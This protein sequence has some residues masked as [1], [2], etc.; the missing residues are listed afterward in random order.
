[1]APNY[2]VSCVNPRRQVG[3]KALETQDLDFDELRS[4]HPTDRNEYIEEEL[5]GDQPS[6]AL[7]AYVLENRLYDT[8]SLAT[9]FM[10]AERYWLLELVLDSLS[11]NEMERMVYELLTEAA[12]EG[13]LK[14]VKFLIQRYPRQIDKQTLDDAFEVAD[15]K[16][17]NYL[18]RF[19]R[20]G[21]RLAQVHGQ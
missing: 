10:E 7:L 16:V 15:A 8:K 11:P 21:R 2:Y 4:M 9:D 20:A 14:G 1:M 18:R 5:M 12:D 19:L 6:V 3:G 17:K 13:D